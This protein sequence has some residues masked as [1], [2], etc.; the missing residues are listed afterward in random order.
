[1]SGEVIFKQGDPSLDLMYVTRGSALITTAGATPDG[2][3]NTVEPG[4]TL[5]E[6]GLF[7]NS[8]RSATATAGPD[9]IAAVV[10]DRYTLERLF[11]SNGRAATGFVRLLSQRLVRALD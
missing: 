2:A 8:P 1:A 5:G 11:A 4:Q 9:G 6:I 3:A 10:I 7:T